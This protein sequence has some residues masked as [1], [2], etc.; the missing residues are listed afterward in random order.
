MKYYHRCAGYP[1]LSGAIERLC[2]NIGLISSTAT[3]A[4]VILVSDYWIEPTDERKKYLYFG[5]K[6][7]EHIIQNFG[8]V[9]YPAPLGAYKN[10]YWMSMI[11]IDET[12]R[13]FVEQ[14]RNQELDATNTTAGPVIVIIDDDEENRRTA[15]EAFPDAVILGSV[16]AGLSFI[17]G[18]T[19]QITAVLTDLVM[20]VQSSRNSHLWNQATADIQ[21]S[22]ILI[23]AAAVKRG[24]PVA[25]VSYGHS[26]SPLEDYFRYSF[27]AL[28]TVPIHSGPKTAEVWRVALLS[29]QIRQ[30]T[31]G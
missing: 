10:A 1:Q 11:E 14:N 7:A 6:L 24:I 21:P 12:L 30:T 15:K 23:Y 20:S 5:P 18:E 3:E 22:G 17:I 2:K 8:N 29:L 28:E 13:L 25:I 9:I 19:R 16:L 31:T 27:T 4:D 26:A